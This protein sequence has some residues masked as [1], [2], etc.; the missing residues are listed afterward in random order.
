MPSISVNSHPSVSSDVRRTMYRVTSSG[1]TDSLRRSDTSVGE[2]KSGEKGEIAIDNDAEHY[3]S[4]HS[5]KAERAV[6]WYGLAKGCRLFIITNINKDISSY[7][8][9]SRICSQR[10]KPAREGNEIKAE[11]TKKIKLRMERKERNRTHKNK[12]RLSVSVKA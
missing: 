8:C 5:R 12:Y 6:L 9:V 7:V 11:T 4:D 10:T 2:E 1:A 3:I